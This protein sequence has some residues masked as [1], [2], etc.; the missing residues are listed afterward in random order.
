MFKI[1]HEKYDKSVFFVKELMKSL[2]E[3]AI[4]KENFDIKEEDKASS[5]FA[6]FIVSTENPVKIQESI[7]PAMSKTMTEDVLKKTA[8]ALTETLLRSSVEEAKNHLVEIEE[9]NNKFKAHNKTPSESF[10]TS[11]YPVYNEYANIKQLKEDAMDISN[12]LLKESDESYKMKFA[13]KKSAFTHALGLC[14]VDTTKQKICE[15]VST[16]FKN[17]II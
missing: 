17:S 13:I 6:S 12:T 15:R 5:R 4:Y 7:F 14:G 8:E 16:E 10:L 1:D 9:L 11:K 3:S 2:Y